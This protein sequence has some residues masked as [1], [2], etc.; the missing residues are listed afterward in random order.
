MCQP[1][2]PIE[3]YA[4]GMLAQSV[5]RVPRPDASS[6]QRTS[7]PP[8]LNSSSFGASAR[9]TVVSVTCGDGAPTV[10][11]FTVRRPKLPKRSQPG[12]DFPKRLGSQPVETALCV[13]GGFHEAALSQHSQVLRYGRLR[14]TKS[15]LDLANRLF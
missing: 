2:A 3:T 10:V 15:T 1:A 8:Q 14:H 9:V 5:R 12:I 11:S 4:R 6:S 13:H 7:P